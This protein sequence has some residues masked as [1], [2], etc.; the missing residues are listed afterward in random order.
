MLNQNP[1]DGSQ[2]RYNRDRII[3]VIGL[4]VL[5][6]VA[7]LYLINLPEDMDN[8]MGMSAAMPGVMPWHR[9]D[10]ISMFVMWGIMMM[11]MMLPT[12]SPMIL[13][14]STVNRQKKERGQ[15]YA[16]TGIFVS[17]YALIWI[18]FSVGAT[19]LNWLL[20]TNSLLSGMMGESTS[21]ILGG[22]LLISAGIFQWTPIKKACLNKCRTPMGF[23]M[24]NWKDGRAGALRMGLEHGMF[25]LGCCWLIMA[26]L[27]VLGV[28]NLIWIAALTVFVLIE[29]IAPKGD[30]ISRIAGIGFV[31]WGG[32]LFI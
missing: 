30:W 6:V 11:G 17:G 2:V 7:W 28:M 22:V 31:I 27:F 13:M 20:H 3:V 19:V 26:L 18:L 25:C 12:A 1:H 9:A 15:S 32:F 4:G 16:E 8:T 24:T 23:L 5:T 21:N 14:F 10:W 29:K